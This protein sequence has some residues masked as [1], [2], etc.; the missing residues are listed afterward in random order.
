MRLEVA[1]EGLGRVPGTLIIVNDEAEAVGRAL[2]SDRLLERIR[3]QLLGHAPRHRPTHDL[4]MERVDHGCEAGQSFGRSDA[5]DVVHPWF[6]TGFGV[7]RP[8]HE[9]H[10]RVAH[11]DRLRA[12]VLP[13]RTLRLQSQLAHDGE[14]PVS[15]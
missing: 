3:E 11:I 15:C 2:P 14:R 7:E 10:A 6:V 4:P 1:P 9:V 8:V 13:A 12:S 5:G